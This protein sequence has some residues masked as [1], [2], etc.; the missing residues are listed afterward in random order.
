M[1]EEEIIILR[2]IAERLRAAVENDNLRTA[3]Y[4]FNKEEV[5]LVHTSIEEYINQND[6]KNKFK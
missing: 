5:T 4:L 6:T 3:S 2:N 1:T